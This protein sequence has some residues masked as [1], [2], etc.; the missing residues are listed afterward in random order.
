MPSFFVV[1]L[2]A[3]DLLLPSL[4]LLFYCSASISL[5]LLKQLC[6]VSKATLPS[7]K[8][9]SHFLLVQLHLNTQQVHQ[10]LY[11]DVFHSRLQGSSGT[12]QFAGSRLLSTPYVVSQCEETTVECLCTGSLSIANTVVPEISPFATVHQI[13]TISTWVSSPSSLFLFSS[14]FFFLLFALVPLS[15]S[16]VN[17]T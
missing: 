10:N 2:S 13:P 8:T 16:L 3:Q 9:G 12:R 5:H 6:E 7:R 15:T 1:S 14:F 11:Q 17:V 4:L